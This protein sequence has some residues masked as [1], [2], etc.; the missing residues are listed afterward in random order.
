[1]VCLTVSSSGHEARCFFGETAAGSPLESMDSFLKQLKAGVV[2]QPLQKVSKSGYKVVMGAPWQPVAGEPEGWLGDD[3]RPF[4][5][6]KLQRVNRT[7][8]TAS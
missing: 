5:G 7:T 1:M 8:F 2:V 3:F 6:K 4:V